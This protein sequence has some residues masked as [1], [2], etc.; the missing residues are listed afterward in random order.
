MICLLHPQLRRSPRRCG[1]NSAWSSSRRRGWWNSSSSIAS[2]GLLRIESDQRRDIRLDSKQCFTV[3]LE[4]D[5]PFGDRVM[6]RHMDIAPKSLQTIRVGQAGSAMCGYK[7]VDS[8]TT[9]FGDQRG[10]DAD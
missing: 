4:I 7:K 10:I 2:S 9:V 1:N 3:N 5:L 6:T 8:F